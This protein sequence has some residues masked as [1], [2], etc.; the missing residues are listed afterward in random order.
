MSKPLMN[1][2]QLKIVIITES[3]TQER[4]RERLQPCLALG[5]PLIKAGCDMIKIR[6][7]HNHFERRYNSDADLSH[8]Q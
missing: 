7:S 1:L 3:K 8:F 2:Y 6:H 4:E 5:Y